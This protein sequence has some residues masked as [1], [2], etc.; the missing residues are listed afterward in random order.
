MGLYAFVYVHMCVCM[1]LRGGQKCIYVPV[2]ICT[3]VYNVFAW[4]PEVDVVSSSLALHLSV[5]RS[6]FLLN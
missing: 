5:L 3:F 2:Y 1:C 6:D 4:R